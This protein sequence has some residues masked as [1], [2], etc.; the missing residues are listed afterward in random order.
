MLDP[1]KS[2]W[3]DLTQKKSTSPERNPKKVQLK[4]II[5]I[6]QEN[7]RQ[8]LRHDTI[9]LFDIK[10]RTLGFSFCQPQK[11]SLPKSLTQ[12]CHYKISNPKKVLRSQIQTQKRA[13]HIPIT[14]IPEYP[15]WGKVSCSELKCRTIRHW[16]KVGRR[17]GQ[18]WKSLQN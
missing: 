6:I 18:E 15:P 14:Y 3:L 2:F 7:S 10:M 8:F 13:S 11:K 16:S 9:I 12:K 4:K 5:I 1:K 17:R